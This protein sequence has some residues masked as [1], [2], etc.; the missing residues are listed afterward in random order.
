MLSKPNT[1]SILRHIE[2]RESHFSNISNTSTIIHGYIRRFESSHKLVIPNEIYILI[3]S[4]YWLFEK[5]RNNITILL[6]FS[7]DNLP[8]KWN[9]KTDE[10]DQKYYIDPTNNQWYNIINLE[11]I[12]PKPL[13]FLQQGVWHSYGWGCQKCTLDNVWKAQLCN[14]CLT[15][16]P[17]NAWQIIMDV[18]NSINFI[19][20]QK[21]MEIRIFDAMDCGSDF[22][23]FY[24]FASCGIYDDDLRNT[25]V[26]LNN[27]YSGLI[28]YVGPIK[29]KLEKCS[30]F[31]IHMCEP[32]GKNNGF[33][34]GYQYF[35][36][37]PNHGLFVTPSQINKIIYENSDD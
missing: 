10:N 34:C 26:V 16:R 30:W 4:F 17:D 25:K 21:L 7:S 9:I 23:Y 2:T 29:G 18:M 35:I 11:N 32:N 20:H 27:G 6:T 19:S 13:R 22:I 5:S 8:K 28:C 31:G 14:A 33:I 15:P 37:K 1:N 36:C 12:A 24:D 3:E